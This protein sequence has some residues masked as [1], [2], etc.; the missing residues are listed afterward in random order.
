MFVEES[1]HFNAEEFICFQGVRLTVEAPGVR[2]NS[3]GTGNGENTMIH[4]FFRTT[5]FSSGNGIAKDFWELLSIILVGESIIVFRA[6]NRDWKLIEFFR[7]C[8]HC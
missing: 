3:L 6:G 7:Y 2:A 4:H 1:T 5:K 8:Y